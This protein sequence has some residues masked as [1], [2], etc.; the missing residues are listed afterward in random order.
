MVIDPTRTTPLKI[1]VTLTL[2]LTLILGLS[3]DAFY[4]SGDTTSSITID[5][6][7]DGGACDAGL[8]A[9]ACRLLF[10]LFKENKKKRWKEGS[11]EVSYKSGFSAA[12]GF[13]SKW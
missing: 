1:N 12:G 3:R 10:P 4:A 9:R 6:G 11:T 13:Q 5:G 8:S 2:T 7:G